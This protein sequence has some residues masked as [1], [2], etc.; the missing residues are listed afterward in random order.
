MLNIVSMWDAQAKKVN[1]YH[2]ASVSRSLQ[3]RNI[4]SDTTDVLPDSARESAGSQTPTSSVDTGSTRRRRSG[5]GLSAML[6]PE[7]QAMAASLGIQGVGRLRKGQ[8]IA[9]IQNV[10]APSGQADDAPAG[11]PGAAA[12]PAAQP[13]P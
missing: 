1:K 10:Q 8:L 12:V 2:P 3:G 6:L 11:T 9:A 13:E 7:L 5:T 4:L